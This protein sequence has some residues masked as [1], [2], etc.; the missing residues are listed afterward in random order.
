MKLQYKRHRTW[1]ELK[2]E[3]SKHYKQSD[4]QPIDVY[5]DKGIFTGWALVEIAQHA[6]R[7]TP[8]KRPVFVEDMLKIKHYAELLI[9]EHYE[10]TENQ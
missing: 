6:I 5:K 2:A 10:K 1:S 8:E 3:G 4:A 9:A 7:N